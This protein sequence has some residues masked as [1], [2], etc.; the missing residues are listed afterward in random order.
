MHQQFY[1]LSVDILCTQLNYFNT[2][3]NNALTKL[4]TAE[5]ITNPTDFNNYESTGIYYLSTASS[6]ANA[7]SEFDSTYSVLEV[8]NFKN[9]NLIKQVL[10]DRWS[11]KTAERIKTGSGWSSW[12][13]YQPKKYTAIGGTNRMTTTTF[14][15]YTI[16]DMSAFTECQ[17]M[18][19][20]W[21]NVVGCYTMRVEDALYRN[22]TDKRILF[23]YQDTSA[24]F[25][26]EIYFAN[27]TTLYAK[28][29]G[30]T[31][32]LSIELVAR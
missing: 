1:N 26:A 19:K 27:S 14:N 17:I 22:S 30:A 25:R 5:V 16:S 29:S 31:G 20:F 10:T 24:T 3:L 18:F 21:D 13:S 12:K 28:S 11:N 4:D 8:S 7:P 23:A 6:I 2:H 9:A 15:S 32:A